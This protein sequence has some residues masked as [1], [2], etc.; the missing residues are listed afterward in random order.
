MG[1][2]ILQK[3]SSVSFSPTPTKDTSSMEPFAQNER[4][5]FDE[6][7]LGGRSRRLHPLEQ[8]INVRIGSPTHDATLSIPPNPELPAESI[9]PHR[10]KRAFEA[11]HTRS[12]ADRSRNRRPSH[13]DENFPSVGK[14]RVYVMRNASALPSPER[15]TSSKTAENPAS[16]ES[17]DA[18]TPSSRSRRKHGL[19]QVD[20]ERIREIRDHV[21]VLERQHGLPITLRSDDESEPHRARPHL[22]H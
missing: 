11:M 1:N 14:Q 8:G 7:Q 6:N 4:D 12:F 22:L 21:C 16:S 13:R 15:G 3:T 2:S 5:E 10:P 19:W 9:S 20:P 18:T 17:V